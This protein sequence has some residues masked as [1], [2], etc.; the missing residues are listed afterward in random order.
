MK[1][2]PKQAI[3]LRDTSTCR[4]GRPLINYTR[5]WDVL[6]RPKQYFVFADR[7]NGRLAGLVTKKHQLDSDLLIAQLLPEVSIA[8]ADWYLVCDEEEESKEDV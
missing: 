8:G 3:L 1:L 4:F 2:N 7:V 5:V 6:G